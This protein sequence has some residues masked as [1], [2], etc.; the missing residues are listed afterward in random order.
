[1]FEE[2]QERSKLKQ[3]EL[4]REIEDKSRDYELTI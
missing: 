2:S 4:E 3:I 1:M